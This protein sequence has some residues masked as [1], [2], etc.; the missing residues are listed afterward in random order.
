MHQT[1]ALG[2]A[3]DYV[4]DANLNVEKV[5]DANGS[6][7]TYSY[8]ANNRVKTITDPLGKVT[9]Y[10]YDRNGNRVQVIDPRGNATTTY[11]NQDNEVILTVDASRFA[12]ATATTATVTSFHGGCTRPARGCT[13]SRHAADTDIPAGDQ[14][15]TFAY[16]SSIALQ[17]APMH[18][19]TQPRTAMTVWAMFSRPSSS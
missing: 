9:T 4:Y 5:T 1:D 17:S 12:T 16:D 19:A 13:R 18:W 10:V 3:T 8:D 15:T 2:N 6:A 7:T 11:Y 14:I